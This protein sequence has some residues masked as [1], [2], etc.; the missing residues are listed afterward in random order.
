MLNFICFFDNSKM[1]GEEN[2][3]YYNICFFPPQKATP[4]RKSIPQRGS[5]CSDSGDESDRES[6][7]GTSTTNGR[8]TNAVTSIRRQSLLSSSLSH[9]RRHHYG[10]FY[11][12]MG[13]VGEL[14]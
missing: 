1:L 14:V 5:M 7:S 6:D 8:V 10:S 9:Q 2:E 4:R 12:R 11:L 3:F 13:A